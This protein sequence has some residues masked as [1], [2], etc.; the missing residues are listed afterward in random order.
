MQAGSSVSS[1]QAAQSF[2]HVG[3]ELSKTKEALQAVW[4]C[5]CPQ[6]VSFPISNWNLLFQF[7]TPASHSPTVPYHGEPISAP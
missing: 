1:G 7:M 3:L 6:E 5:D 4:S 2:T